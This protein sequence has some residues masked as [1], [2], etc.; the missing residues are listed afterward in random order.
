M[1]L[2]DKEI[3]TERANVGSILEKTENPRPTITSVSNKSIPQ[4]T[5]NIKPSDFKPFSILETLPLSELFCCE[6]L[7]FFDVCVTLL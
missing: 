7:L 4:S 3:D 6:G 5:Q 2:L 1:F